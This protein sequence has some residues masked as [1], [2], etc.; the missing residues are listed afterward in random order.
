MIK[1]IQILLTV[2]LAFFTIAAAASIPA[3]SAAS[4]I[5]GFEVFCFYSHS[6][7]DD[8][9]VSPGQPGMAMHLHD[10]AGNTSTN[11]NSTPA[12]LRASSSNCKLKADTAAYWT[13][14]LYSHGHA[15]HPDRLH[16]YY[17][18][19]QVNNYAGIRPM[20]AGLKM[21]AGNPMATAPQSTRVVAW[22]CGVQGAALHDRP[23]SCLPGQKIVLHVFFPNC[24]DGVHLDSA[25]HHSHMAY[26]YHGSCPKSHPVSIPRLSEDYGY[27]IIDASKITF[28][29]GSYLTAHADFWNTWDQAA[30]RRL[31]HECINQGRQCGPQVG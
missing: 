15:V 4:T 21:V 1:R 30:M 25:N 7:K 8:P 10:F 28:A 20:P 24:W 26:S 18:W 17:R 31:T 29:S 13:P 19:G 9:I 23:V 14:T 2:A 22:G 12:T 11:A 3:A 5:P 27:P 6:A 16:A